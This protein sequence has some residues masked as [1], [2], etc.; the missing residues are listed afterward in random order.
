MSNLSKKSYLT[1]YLAWIVAPTP[2]QSFEVYLNACWGEHWKHFAIYRF[3]VERTIPG[4]IE[5]SLRRFWLKVNYY[6]KYEMWS[7]IFP[8]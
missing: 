1:D 3:W 4:I 2:E 8:K 5:L 7:E 6:M